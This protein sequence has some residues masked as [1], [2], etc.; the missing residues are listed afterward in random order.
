MQSDLAAYCKDGKL[1]TIE[2]IR[3]DRLHHYRRL[4]YNIT[5]DA[6][7]SAYPITRTILTENHWS[8]MVDEFIA[9]HKAQHA[10]LYLMPGELLEF[11]L[12]KRYAEKFDV[13][14]LMDLLQ[15]E[16]V[17]VLVHSMADCDESDVQPI[18]DVLND[19]LIVTPY[20][21]IL[22]LDFPV[23][24]L[25]SANIYGLNEK[26]Y[27]LVHRE[28]S[29]TVQ[30]TLLNEL[31]YHL[32]NELTSTNKSLIEILSPLVGNMEINE[33]QNFLNGAIQFVQKLIE[34]EI[35]IGK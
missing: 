33:K 31:T 35:I 9:E 19:I 23:H 28:K 27:H 26:S 5:A 15:F 18:E 8:Q 20:H 2:G 12:E 22:V 6:L 16:W 13:P 29:G 7:E 1:R 14:Y 24:Q 3:E 17:E 25:K 21:K 32:I 30:Y 34:R 4:V 11:A 10:Q